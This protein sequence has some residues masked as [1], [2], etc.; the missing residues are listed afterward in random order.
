[1]TAHRTPPKKQAKK[2]AKVKTLNVWWMIRDQKG[3]YWHHTARYT[4]SP[5]I[6]DF[7]RD[8][9]ASYRDPPYTPTWRDL[10]LDGYRC[11]RVEIRVLSK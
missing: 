11:E 9:Q 1:M 5:C 8:C 10:K 3:E 7:V 4:R 2:A 6:Y